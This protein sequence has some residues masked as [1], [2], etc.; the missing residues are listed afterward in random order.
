MRRIELKA[1]GFAML[2]GGALLV[3]CSSP[4]FPWGTKTR[5]VQSVAVD[6]ARGL[7]FAGVAWSGGHG[8]P[9]VEVHVLAVSDGGEIRKVGEIG[10]YGGIADLWYDAASRTLYEAMNYDGLR[11]A[12]VSDPENPRIVGS[13]STP[14]EAEAV[15][16]SGPYAFVADWKAGLR[17]MDVSDPE[18]LREVGA[19]D[20]PGY[21]VAVAISGHYAYVADWEAGLRVI[22]VSDPGNPREVGAYD[23][24]GYAADVAVSGNHAYVADREEGLRV[25]DVSD[26][27]NPREVGSYDPPGYVEAVAVSGR[28]VYVVGE[29]FRVIDVSDPENPVE[30]GTY[31]LPD[32]AA[33][34]AVSGRYACRGFGGRSP[35]D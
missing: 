15:V 12:D 14:G 10:D 28:Y 20:T 18:N 16:V 35:G 17:V 25:I 30:V 7:V 32:P 4:F 34:L 29:S 24:P 8:P 11:V 1:V 6:E 13:H 9:V 21:A 26:P 5:F 23:T 22:D 3:G 27:A 19:Y 2:G 31:N 33:D